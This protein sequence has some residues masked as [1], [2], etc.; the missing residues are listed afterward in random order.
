MKK[1][2]KRRD[3]HLKE[4]Y[5][6]LGCKLEHGEIT[7]KN[8]NKTRRPPNAVISEKFGISCVHQ[9]NV[10][11][12]LPMLNLHLLGDRNFSSNYNIG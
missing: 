10:S 3:I 9:V 4:K 2:R 12:T 8:I 1:K 11:L 5:I 6:E 7:P